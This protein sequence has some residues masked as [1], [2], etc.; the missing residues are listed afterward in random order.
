MTEMKVEYADRE[1]APNGGSLP[2]DFA[3]YLEDICN[4]R[5]VIGYHLVAVLP[6]ALSDGHIGGAWLFFARRQED[7]IAVEAADLGI[8]TLDF[9]L[10]AIIPPRGTPE[11]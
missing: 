9:E 6:G 3:V 2:E 5:S 11:N 10:P 1:L 4:A 7:S 8:A